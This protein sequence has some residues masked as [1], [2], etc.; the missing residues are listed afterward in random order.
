MF[1]IL[2]LSAVFA[3]LAV[4][5]WRARQRLPKGPSPLPLIGNL[6]QLV[7]KCW[8]AGGTVGGFNEFRKEFGNVFTI[9]MGPIPTV[10]ITDFEVAH[11]THV[12]RA[13]TFGVR[14]SNGGMNYIREGRGIIASNGEFW[15]EHRRFALKTLRDFGLGRNI[16]EEKI[17]EEY[18]YR[19]QDYKKNNFKN[20]GI[21]VHASS[22]FDLLVGSIINTLLVSER[23]E[24]DD[25][26]FEKMKLN[27]AKTLEKVSIFDA[28]TPLAVFKSD[29]WKWRTKKIFGPFDFIF[30]MVQK[31]IQKRVDAIAS[32]KHIISEEGED[33]VDAF[34]IKMEKDKKDGVK[35]STFTLETLAIDLYDLWLAGQETTST[36]L[37]WACAC[38]LNHPEVVAEL[39][40]ELVGITGGTRG[41]SLT[42]K[43]NTP[44]LNATV[45]EIQR[46]ASILNT[47]LFR[48]LQEDTV[49]DGQPVSA[50]AVVT[51]QMSLLHTNEAVFK[52][53]TVFDP[54]RFM[55][56]NNL[57]KTLI[58]FGIGKRACLG[59]SLARA[60][61]YLITGNLV[62][63]YSFEPV[64]TKPE[65][66]TLSPFGLMKRPPN[67]NIR[68]VPVNN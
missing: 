53:H 65:I 54:S 27:L 42:D 38:L 6:H 33:F 23:F 22:C 16:M 63:D 1:F 12:K 8:K 43:P 52:N 21:E 10:H 5:L 20:G 39:R 17:M 25:E 60:E 32:G 29:L 2:V 4:N 58:P 62:L 44:Y 40:S 56:N 7:Y 59:E 45:N 3:V 15:Q 26:D 9:W 46:I 19:F 28:F 36:T 61:L 68:F 64:G 51:T 11:E 49:I 35:D 37:T 24:Q 18:N 47:N 55:E 13:N 41:L 30:G 67:Y 57:E 66:K 50:G 34:L 48:Q 31:G 14:Y